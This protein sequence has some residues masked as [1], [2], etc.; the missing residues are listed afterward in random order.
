MVPTT[1]ERVNTMIVENENMTF[2]ET[3]CTIEHNGRQYTSGGAAYDGERLVA[4]A[5]ENE[6]L[7]DWHGNPIG[8][9]R[10]RSSK[11]TPGSHMGPR[12]FYGRAVVGGVVYSVQGFG[13]GMIV[14]GKRTKQP[15]C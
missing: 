14:H 6:T 9:Y 15:F 2:V 12:Y 1:M 3:D 4:Y 8:S 5:G 10:W 13:K 11:A 7:T